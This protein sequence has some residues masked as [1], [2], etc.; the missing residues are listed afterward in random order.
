MWPSG[1]LAIQGH[2]TLSPARVYVVTSNG[3]AKIPLSIATTAAAV[4]FSFGPSFVSFIINR[5]DFLRANKRPTLRPTGLGP[6]AHLNSYFIASAVS[7]FKS[8]ETF[9]P[10]PCFVSSVLT[11]PIDQLITILSSFKGREKR[12]KTT[13]TAKVPFISYGC[14]L[15]WQCKHQKENSMC[16]PVF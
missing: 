7:R 6:A 12:R 4:L 13:T 9:P 10:L 2:L 5:Q 16:A 3:S 11:P 1:L 14:Q 8:N 15:F